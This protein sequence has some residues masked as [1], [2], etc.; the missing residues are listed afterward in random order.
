MQSIYGLPKIHKEGVQLQT[1]YQQY[2]LIYNI[3]KYFASIL[4]PLIG[5][6]LHQIH[7]STDF[8]KKIQ[9]LKLS[10]KMM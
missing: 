5:N 3:A 2:Q 10:L 9:H 8:G 1:H 7:T 6:T 4:A